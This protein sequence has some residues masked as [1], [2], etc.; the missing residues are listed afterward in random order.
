MEQ[1]ITLR[2]LR[3]A[4]MLAEQLHFGRAAERLGIAQPPLSVQ[5]QQLESFLG[6]SLFERSPRHVRLTA[7]GAAFAEKARAILK[8]V[9]PAVDETRR[10]D[11][12]ESGRLAVAYPGSLL[13]TLVPK[14]VREFRLRNPAIAIDLVEAGSTHQAELLASRR[15]DVGLAR[16]PGEEGDIQRE[17]LL[18]ERLVVAVPARHP[19]AAATPIA[20]RQ[21][22]GVPLVFFPRA[23][24]PILHDRVFDLF[25][26]AGFEPS[27][28]QESSEW[29]TIV[30][31]VQA[32]IGISIVP[33]S[34]AAITPELVRYRPLRAS[35]RTRI[36]LCLA[37]G[38]A[39]PAVA[40]F[41]AVARDVVRLRTPPSHNRT[42]RFS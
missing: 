33:E 6:V 22:A 38:S 12:G 39:D 41:V 37:Q 3:Y 8:S 28:V 27:I 5:I 9:D 10:L 19:L 14:I 24:H 34:F 42:V 35:L 17:I 32:G 36:V 16:D 40:K 1:E 31:L 18:S 25:R 21:L 13:F 23:A 15:V 11:R 29:L 20:P 26:N 7:A 30:A 2:Q 4:T